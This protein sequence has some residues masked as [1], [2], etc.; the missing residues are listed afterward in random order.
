[1]Q[2][3]FFLSWTLFE[4]GSPGHRQQDPRAVFLGEGS[5]SMA[6][7]AHKYSVLLPTYNERENI[8]LVIYM[9][10]QAFEKG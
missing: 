10:M 8:P 6:A 2:A 3:L 9:I 1:L 7:R 5:T 4:T